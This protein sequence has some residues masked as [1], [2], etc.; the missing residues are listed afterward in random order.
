MES[1][2]LSPAPLPA[3]V[4]SELKSVNDLFEFSSKWE[5]APQGLGQLYVPSHTPDGAA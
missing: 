5:Q 2:P 3:V 1:F 4:C